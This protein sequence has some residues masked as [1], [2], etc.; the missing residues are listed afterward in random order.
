MRLIRSKVHEVLEQE[1]APLIDTVE[2]LQGQ[3]VECIIISFATSDSNYIAGVKS[4]LFNP[5]RINVML[6]RA[7]TK[8]VI[9]ACKEIQME[10]KSIL[11]Q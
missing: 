2:R 1:A 8:V 6:S 11:K 3:D 5:N 9:Y 10:L 7:K 4:F